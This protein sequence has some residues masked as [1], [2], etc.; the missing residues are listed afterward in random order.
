MKN[1]IIITLTFLS[2]NI[3]AQKTKNEQHTLFGSE[4][5]S[6]RG[7]IALNHKAISINNQI[8]LLTG[9]ELSLVFNHKLNFGLFGYGM[10]N[11]IQSNYV[12]NYN[13]RYFFEYGNGGLKIEPVFLSN[14]VIHFTTPI[15]IGIGGISLNRN[16]FY[17]DDYNWD[18][19]ENRYDIFGFVE[20]GVKAE[21]NLFRN[22]RFSGGIGYQFTDV[23]NLAKTDIYPLNGWTVNAALKFGWF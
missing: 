16:R 14:S 9:G 8:G 23:I 5:K 11:D 6:V 20:P 13:H 1:L 12:D 3:I 22:L 4:K 10:Y 19:N 2:V 15:K 21:V 17:H 7:Y 18:D